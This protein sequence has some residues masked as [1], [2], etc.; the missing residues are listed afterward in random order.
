MTHEYFSIHQYSC[1]VMFVQAKMGQ[2]LLWSHIQIF[3]TSQDLYIF[4]TLKT[5]MEVNVALWELSL[6]AQKY[7][8]KL[9]ANSCKFQASLYFFLQSNSNNSQKK[10]HL[11][12]LIHTILATLCKPKPKPGDETYCGF[13]HQQPSLSSYWILWLHLFWFWTLFFYP[14]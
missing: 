4:D 13:V 7:K 2:Q 10:S 14:T 3:L 1:F 11:M 12:Q 9:F 5:N 6:I 8:L